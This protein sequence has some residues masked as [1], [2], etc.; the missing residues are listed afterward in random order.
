[1]RALATPL[2]LAMLFALEVAA[3]ARAL[4]WPELI[5]AALADAPLAPP[6][7]S[8]SG[9]GAGLEQLSPW[10]D[11]PMSELLVGELD[12][13]EV[14]ISGFVVPLDLAEDDRVREFLL[15]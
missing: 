5:P 1:M 13:T 8:H 12:G 9:F 10:G 4:R 6:P 2:L 15:V 14:T 11:L 3:E 7:V